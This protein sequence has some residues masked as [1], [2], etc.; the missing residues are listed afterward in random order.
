MPTQPFVNL[1]QY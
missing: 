1:V